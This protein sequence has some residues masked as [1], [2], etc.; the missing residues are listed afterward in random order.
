MTGQREMQEAGPPHLRAE[1]LNACAG[2]VHGFFGRRGGVSAGLYGALNCGPGSG[3]DSEHVAANRAT[4]ARAL[5]V[6][7]DRLVT[8]YQVHSPEVV[9][10]RRPWT[11]ETAP[12]ADAMVTSE[13]GIALG[14]LTA[15]C[16]PVLLADRPAR[17]IGALHAGWKGA[18][19]GVIDSAIAAMED[20]GAARKNIRA[21]VGPCIGQANYEV[22]AEF[23]ARFLEAH[24]GNDRFF[25]PSDRAN[26]WR[27][28]LPGYVSAR[29]AAAGVRDPQVMGTCTYADEAAYFS[30]RR[31][32]H[33]GE[34]DYGRNLSAIVMQ[35]E[36]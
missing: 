2:V 10:V 12:R 28:D 15:D 13:P 26:H 14:I 16:A 5:G 3:D 1:T 19:S 6:T 11:R 34:P 7:P 24:A 8:L 25:A 31:A 4:A 22:G 20:V 18:L 33:R 35:P 21:A 23:H 32:T 36:R 27:F 17:V 9:T 30:Y 29:L